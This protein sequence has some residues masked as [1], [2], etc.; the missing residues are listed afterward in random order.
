M[1]S[2]SASFRMN[3]PGPSSPEMKQSSWESGLFQFG[4]PASRAISRTR[5][6]RSSPSGKSA[7]E[8]CAG[9]RPQRNYDWSFERSSA[10]RRRI[11]PVP[12]SFSIRA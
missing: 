5:L 9:V 7:R 3:S 11:S 4:S 1:P 8:S 10:R 2:A 6:F 12:A